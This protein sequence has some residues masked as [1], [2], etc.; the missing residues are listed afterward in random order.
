MDEAPSL[1]YLENW[2]KDGALEYFCNRWRR[3]PAMQPFA[4]WCTTAKNGEW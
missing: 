1:R 4:E 2:L 3:Y